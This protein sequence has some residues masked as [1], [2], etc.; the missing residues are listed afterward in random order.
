[1]TRLRGCDK[2]QML[3]P[4]AWVSRVIPK[5]NATRVF[6]YVGLDSVDTMPLLKVGINARTRSLSN[7]IITEVIAGA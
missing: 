3:Q 7:A 6:F 1:M 2:R 4:L 5:I